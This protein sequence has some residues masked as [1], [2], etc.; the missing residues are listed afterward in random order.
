MGRGCPGP[1]GLGSKLVLLLPAPSLA[2]PHPLQAGAGVRGARALQ[3]HPTDEHLLGIVPAPLA[4]G[5]QP[6]AVEG[7]QEGAVVDQAPGQHTGEAVWKRLLPDRDRPVVQLRGGLG[8]RVVE[9]DAV[10][11]TLSVAERTKPPRIYSLPVILEG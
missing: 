9:G 5:A 3:P 7:A 4:P 2:R 8:A 1:S 6:Q 11:I 10:L